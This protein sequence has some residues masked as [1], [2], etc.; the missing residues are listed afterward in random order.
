MELT[1]VRQS[2]RPTSASPIAGRRFLPNLV[3]LCPLAVRYSKIRLPKRKRL[4]FTEYADYRSTGRR[5]AIFRN[6]G[7][8]QESCLLLAAQVCALQRRV[9]V[10]CVVFLRLVSGMWIFRITGVWAEGRGRW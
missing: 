1:E 6:A 3:Q 10:F 8:Q 2:N 9:R 4:V 7:R 5:A